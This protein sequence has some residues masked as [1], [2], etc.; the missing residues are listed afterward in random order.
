MQQCR[1]R[2]EQRLLSTCVSAW[3]YCRHKE[4]KQK[5]Q[6]QLLALVL[7]A[8]QQVSACNRSGRPTVNTMKQPRCMMHSCAPDTPR[9]TRLKIGDGTRPC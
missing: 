1:R 5:Q 8:W 7:Q 4:Q 9:R 3:R 6:A 2:Q